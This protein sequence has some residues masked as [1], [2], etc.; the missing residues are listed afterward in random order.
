MDDNGKCLDD[1]TN[2]LRRIEDKVHLSNVHDWVIK[3][4]TG[5]PSDRKTDYLRLLEY[6]LKSDES[7]Q[8]PFLSPPPDGPLRMAVVELARPPRTSWL[9][10]GGG[11]CENDATATNDD[12]TA[13][14]VNTTASTGGKRLPVDSQPDD[15]PNTAPTPVACPELANLVDRTD[16]QTVSLQQFI[17]DAQRFTCDGGQLMKRVADRQLGEFEQSAAAAFD[18][19]AQ[20]LG[21]ALAKEQIALL[22]R[23]R[24]TEQRMLSRAQILQDHLRELLPTF[25]YDQFVAHPHKHIKRVVMLKRKKATSAMRSGDAKSGGTMSG[26]D[27]DDGENVNDDDDDDDE[28]NDDD[29]DDADDETAAAMAQQ[30]KKTQCALDW[31]RSELER[32]DCENITLSKKYDELVAAIGNASQRKLADECRVMERKCA[33]K[34]QLDLLRK[35]SAKQVALIDDYME[36]IRLKS[37]DLNDVSKC[38]S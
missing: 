24:T 38:R 35:Q 16:V 13:C 34:A 4:T 15:Q 1:I 31:L 8:E 33:A 5:E 3:L 2:L 30:D 32:A 36:R 10:A 6:M 19:R 25:Q 23:Y 9:T 26:Y 7:V 29:S 17:A 18:E 37:R 21:D 14:S 20:K 28:D 22:L 12:V 11:G 27:D